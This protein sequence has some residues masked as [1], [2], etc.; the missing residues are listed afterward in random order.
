MTPLY[1]PTG[2]YP[3][4]PD[5]SPE[6]S[7]CAIPTMRPV[8]VVEAIDADIDPVVHQVTCAYCGSEYAE[9]EDCCPGCGARETLDKVNVY[10]EAAEQLKE[11]LKQME[12]QAQY[13][14]YQLQKA[15]RKDL[16]IKPLWKR[17]LEV[18][19]RYP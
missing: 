10:E 14:D 6:Y 9:S 1:S 15:M 4:P 11:Q 13:A 7:T 19:V 16:E 3:I 2:F 18:W 8:A 5:Y 17:L 12:L